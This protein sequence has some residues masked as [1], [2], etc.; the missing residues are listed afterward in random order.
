MK[1]KAALADVSDALKEYAELEGKAED[2]LLDDNDRLVREIISHGKHKN[3]SFFAFTATPKSAT[4]EMFGTEW[5]DS[6]YHPFHVYSMRQAIE[7]GF[8]LDVLQNYTTYKTCYQIAKNT[9]DNPEVPESKALKTIRKYEELHPY[10]I[11]QKSAIIVETFRNVTKQKIKGKGKM[12]VVTSSRLAAVR[13]YHE[14]K[15][16]LEL[17]GYHDVEILAAFSGSIK[18]PEDAAEIEWTESKLNGVNE[19]QTKQLFH[20]EGNILIVAEKYQTG[21]DEPLLHTMIVDKKLRGVK[22]VQTL[23]RL[24][25]THPDKQDTFIIDFVNTKE[26]ILKAFQPFYQETSLAQEINTDLIY[27]TQKMLR[28][29]NIYNDA[30]IASVNEIYFDEDKRKA[31]K[32][33]AAVTNA[34]LPVQQKYNALNQEQRYQFRKLC[35]TFVKWYGYITQIARMFDKQMHNEYIFCSYLAKIVPADPTTPFDLDNRVKLEYYNLEKT[36]EG[37]IELVKEEKSVYEPAKLKKPVKM[38]ETL[39]PLEKVIEKINQQY[40]G[41]FTEG[42][43]VVITALHQKLKSNKKLMKSAKTDGRQIFE[44]NIFPQLF[45]D[46]AQEAY[47]E[48]TETYTKLFED[49]GKYHAIMS[50]LAQIMFD[51]LKNEKE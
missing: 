44:K 2:E 43:K 4:L 40:M 39:S 6:S 19:S 47:I 24:N 33:Q 37:S 29:F 15:N 8:I 14:I 32:I 48:S 9:K 46:A 35:R 1:L 11:Q 51:E 13:Y 22:A 16:Y 36:Y 42:D 41:N 27:K 12:M 18:D 50:A 21:F 28:A 30:D 26:D 5:N 49:A 10:N 7:E 38:V 17:N 3:L 20:N 45:N 25:R 34:L 31:N 23:S